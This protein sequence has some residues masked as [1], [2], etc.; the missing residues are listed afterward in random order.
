MEE[1]DNK[2][3]EFDSIFT[4]HSSTVRNRKLRPLLLLEHGYL[5]SPVT[6][7]TGYH[8]LHPKVPLHQHNAR[9]MIVLHTFLPNELSEDE[10]REK[11]IY[12]SKVSDTIVL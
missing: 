3:S 5:D 1:R 12:L 11:C 2:L 9:H 7:S 6:V 4:E 10:V 8:D